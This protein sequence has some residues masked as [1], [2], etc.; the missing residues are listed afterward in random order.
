MTLSDLQRR[1]TKGDISP[2]DICKYARAV[3]PRTTTFGEVINTWGEAYFYGASHTLISR[4]KA[5]ASP[6]F[7]DP[8]CAHSAWPIATKF[9]TV[10]HGKGCVSR[11]QPCPIPRVCLTGSGTISVQREWGS[12]TFSQSFGTSYMRPHD[13]RNSYQFFH[14]KLDDRRIHRFDHTSGP[15]EFFCDKCWP[16]MSLVNFLLQYNKKVSYHKQ[17]VLQHSSGS[18]SE[19]MSK[20]LYHLRPCLSDRECS[21]PSEKL[22]IPITSPWTMWL[23]FVSPRWCLLGSPQILCH[24]LPA[25]SYARLFLTTKTCLL[26]GWVCVPNGIA[27]G[28]GKWV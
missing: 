23:P 15:G 6:K 14:D 4:G 11:G 7:W 13:M 27:L 10:T 5:P 1:D 22:L 24:W 9:G 18:N 28:L 12:S 16:A 8:Y 26:P 2:A 25:P 17:I 3:W 20:N 21:G 19:Y